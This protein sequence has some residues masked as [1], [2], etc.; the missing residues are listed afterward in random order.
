M[1]ITINGKEYN[2]LNEAI[3]AEKEFSSFMQQEIADRKSKD[4]T[5]KHIDELTQKAKQYDEMI[6][7][8]TKNQESIK[9]LEE[10]QKIVD[11]ALKG[12][13]DA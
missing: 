8:Y 12:G 1:K 2:T 3:E 7:D 11:A 13:Q 4:A 9:S 5:T 6:A 10:N